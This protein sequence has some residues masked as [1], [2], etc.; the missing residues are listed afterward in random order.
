MIRCLFEVGLPI[1][2]RGVL[3]GNRRRRRLPQQ[4]VQQLGLFCHG[5]LNGGAHVG[6]ALGDFDAGVF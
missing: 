6:G 3:R 1:N 2:L 5:S 4:R